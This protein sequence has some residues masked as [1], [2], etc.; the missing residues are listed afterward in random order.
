MKITPYANVVISLTGQAQQNALQSV[1]AELIRLYWN[2][3]DYL[4]GESAKPSWGDSFIGAAADC[5]KE[6]CPGAKGIA[7]R[8][9]YRMRQFYETHKGDEFVSPLATRISWANHLLIMSSTKA[10]EEKEFYIGLCVKEKYSKRELERQTSSAHYQR[11]ML[12]TQKLAPAEIE[13]N[14]NVRFLDSYVLEFLDLP[15]KHSESGLKQA[16]VQ[17]L[18]NFVLEIGKGFTFVDEEYHVQAG[19]SD[20]FPLLYIHSSWRLSKESSVTAI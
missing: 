13:H 4:S 19:N 8:G 17:N 9:L 18:K 10:I 7:R 3:G 14:K 11:Y 6:N 12:S 2:A 5:I 16:I 1:N 15:K 20:F